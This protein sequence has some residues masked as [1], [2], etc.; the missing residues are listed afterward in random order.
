MADIMCFYQDLKNLQVPQQV[1][2]KFNYGEALIKLHNTYKQFNTG[3]FT[4]ITD[5][6]TRHLSNINLPYEVKSYDLD[7]ATLMENVCIAN[8]NAV[9]RRPGRYVL[10]GADHLINGNIDKLFKAKHRFDLGIMM[11]KGRVNNTVILINTGYDGLHTNQH[12]LVERF[13][14][15]RYE[16]FKTL[17]YDQ[18]HWGGDQFAITKLLR[19]EGILP[20]RKKKVRTYS[21]MGLQIRLFDYNTSGIT[22]VSKSGPAFDDAA[23]FIDFKGPKRKRYFDQIYTYITLKGDQAPAS[24]V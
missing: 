14:E 8:I 1:A 6:Q 22:G 13:F 12:E 20:E 17:D 19:E 4:W 10:C 18:K 21:C 3:Q 5:H 9:R 16:V 15:R 7:G 11:I 24:I 23:C 2:K